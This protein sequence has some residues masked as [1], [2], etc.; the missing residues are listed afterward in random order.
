M[1]DYKPIIRLCFQTALSKGTEQRL[2]LGLLSTANLMTMSCVAP[3]TVMAIPFYLTYK[4]NTIKASNDNDA[5]AI[6]T[7][8]YKRIF[9]RRNVYFQLRK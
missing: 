3:C 6:I 8:A 1:L 9:V 7:L 5:N 2:A 4:A